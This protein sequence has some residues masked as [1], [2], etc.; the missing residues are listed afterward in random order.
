MDETGFGI[1]EAHHS[2]QVI[3]TQQRQGKSCFLSSPEKQEWVTSI[4]AVTAAGIAL[5]PLI[6][7][8]SQS[9]DKKNFNNRWKPKSGVDDWVW[10][11]SD[12][13]WSNDFLATEW[14]HNNLLPF[15][16]NYELHKRTL[17]IIDGH[18]S[19]VKALFIAACIRNDIDLLVLPAHTSHL[20]QPLDRTIFGPLKKR[21]D[22]LTQQYARFDRNR[23]AKAEWVKLLVK[24]R[25]EAL[26]ASNIKAAFRTMGIHPYAPNLLLVQ[27]D[28]EVNIDNC[29]ETKKM[30]VPK[31]IY[32]TAASTPSSVSA[33]SWRFLSKE[34]DACNDAARDMIMHLSQSLEQ[35][36]AE[37]LL[38]REELAGLKEAHVRQARKNLVTVSMLDT[39]VPRR[40]GEYN[41]HSA[42]ENACGHVCKSVIVPTGNVHL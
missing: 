6:I 16:Q 13:G 1:G 29:A 18:G 36:D 26:T 27:M 31:A 34:P 14:L 23:I 42:L 8:K 7:M 12:S 37:M 15:L 21:I 19:H 30:T 35:R 41:F 24:A 22:Q 32:K 17:L 11:T 9:E 2:H 38:L 5:P 3:V 10:S 4:E 33:E 40:N 39:H 25:I 28:S 20:T